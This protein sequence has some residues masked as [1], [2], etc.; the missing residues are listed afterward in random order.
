MIALTIDCEQWNCPLLEGHDVP[1]NGETRQSREGNIR[2]LRL[3]RSTKVPATFFVTGDYA[4]GEPAQVRKIA[5]AGHEIACH[6]HS[7]YYRG[8]AE[9]DLAADIKLAKQTLERVVGT[10]ILGFRSPQMQY[11]TQLL[12]ILDK[13]GFAYDS[14]LHP[15]YLPGFYNHACS[16]LAPFRP[17]PHHLIVEIPVAVSR[18]RLP[19]S[20][21]FTRV[22]GVRRTIGACRWLLAQGVTPVLYFH[23]WEFIP[24]RSRHVPF[25]YNI[26]TGPP[27]LADVERLINTFGPDQFCR[28][29]DLLRDPVTVA[30]EKEED[31]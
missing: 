19:I 26:Q 12:E 3:L 28:V 9:L 15:A 1:E 22:L 13:F 16:P 17:L 14:S 18:H 7:H 24:M 23:S 11:S 30:K 6:G 5:G 4:L 27:L 25:Y 10:K 31:S 21:L 29:R 8:N 20:W 2:L